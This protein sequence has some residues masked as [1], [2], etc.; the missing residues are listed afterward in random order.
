M[1]EVVHAFPLKPIRTDVELDEAIEMI[2][3]LLDH[4]E[5]APGEGDFLAVLSD[6]VH[7]Y[8]NAHV[9]IPTVGGVAVLRYLMEQNGLTQADLTPQLGSKSTVSEVLSG[10]RELSKAHIRRLSERFGLP[11]DVFLD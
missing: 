1:A 7:R 3:R 8:E 2:D 6:L 10:K 9:E 5:L 11:A 4:G